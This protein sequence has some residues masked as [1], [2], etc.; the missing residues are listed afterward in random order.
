MWELDY[1]ESW[2]LQNWCFWTVVLEKTL[3]SPLD[4]QEIKPVNPK[5]NQLWVFIGR[6]VTEA[7]APILWPP[8][9]KSQSL[10][11]TLMLGKT[12][13]KERG[14]Q[15]MRWLHGF[16]DSTDMNPR[17]FQEIVEDSAAWHA[18]VYGV[19]KDDAWNTEWSR[20][21]ANRVLPRE[22]TGQSKHPLPT[23]KE[24]T[25]HV[26]ITRWSMPKPDWL[27]SLQPKMEKFYTVSK[28]KT[29]SWLWLRSWTPYCQIQT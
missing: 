28:N 5:G 2:A 23:T 8:D 7:E 15:R 14:W 18:A 4:C 19:T 6:T 21:K 13:A 27:Y 26:D 3:E 10:E 16:T 25:L 9:A 20:A 11:E 24:K 17:K 29:G 22:R 12:E 1:K